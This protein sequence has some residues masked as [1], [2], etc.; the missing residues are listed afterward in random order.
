[1]AKKT[2]NMPQPKSFIPKIMPYPPG[3]PIDEVQREYGLDSVI[4]L[5][6]NENPLG[7]SPKAIQAMQKAAADMH[8]YPD[9]NGYY[10]KEALEKKF[11]VGADHIIL[12]NGSDEISD[13]IVTAY[14]R[15]SDSVVV[16]EH[17]FISYKLG[18]MT[19]GAAVKDVP[20]KD[21]HTDL[22]AVA[23]AVDSK[24]RL[25]CIANPMNPV[26]S[27]TTR[28][29]FEAFMKK[30]PGDVLVLLDQAYAEYVDNG[31]YFEG[32]R[33]LKQYPNLIVTR[34]FSK[35]YGLAGLRIGYGFAHPEI[36]KNFDRVRPPFNVNRMAQFT[37]LAALGDKAHIERSVK[38]NNQGRKTLEEAFEKLGIEY[39]PSFTNFILVNVARNVAEVTESLL[40]QGV[41]VRPMAGYG[42]PTHIRVTIGRAGENR[43][44]LTALR[45]TLKEV[46]PADSR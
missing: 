11:S 12:A 23:K 10:L 34:T 15:Q 21:W 38:S 26:G 40:R 41:I 4:K 5:A 13:M 8:I 20:L 27:M 29:D 31:N 6:S 9:G 25:V 43:R 14:V 45:R 28:K 16:S 19:A 32:T 35:A 7:P 46:E 2:Q 24:T 36:I 1:M 44:F 30:V 18:A 37:A 42:L 3:K 39:V 17:D 22:N 33:Y